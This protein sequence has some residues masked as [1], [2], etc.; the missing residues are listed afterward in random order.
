MQR[1]R[2]ELP[3]SEHHQLTQNE[4]YF[5]LVNDE[6]REKIMFHDYGRIYQSPGLYEQIFYD[7]LRCKS[8]TTV[9]DLLHKAVHN[10][11]EN[12]TEMRVLDLGAGNGLVAEAIK[13]Y[14]ASR[15]VGADIIPEAEMASY[16]DR[17]GVYDG[18]YVSDFTELNAETKSELEDWAFDCL[19]T[20][21]ALGFGDIPV[22]AFV[23]AINLV[24]DDGW[25]A[26]NIKDSFLNPSDVSG[27]SKLIR[28]LLLSDY[29]DLHFIERYRH[30][31]SMEGVPL[32]Y[33]AIVGK[34]K[35]SIPLHFVSENFDNSQ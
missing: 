31:L 6:Q 13:K 5:Y 22:M 24:K 29:F 19:T 20:V 10:S 8:P 4:A 33:F 2:I 32:Y 3:I 9:V 28:R 30:R 23:N 18:Y 34:K 27:F 12:F 16:R 11:N 7:R 15:I 1:H 14:G 21:A 17:P 26:F 35:N 25:I